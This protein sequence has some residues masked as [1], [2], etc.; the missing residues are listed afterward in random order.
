MATAALLHFEGDAAAL[1][2]WI[3]GPHTGAHWDVSATV[4]F[5]TGKKD[6]SLVSAIAR[7]FRTGI[8]SL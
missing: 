4:K 7:I 5:L 2:R 8:P 6:K 3:G 1:V